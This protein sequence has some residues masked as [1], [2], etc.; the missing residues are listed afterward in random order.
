MSQISGRSRSSVAR[1]MRVNKHFGKRSSENRRPRENARPGFVRPASRGRVT[2]GIR[3]VFGRARVRLRPGE[4]EGAMERSGPSRPGCF[5]G[6]KGVVMEFWCRGEGGIHDT[7]RAGADAVAR[8]A[9]SHD[10]STGS[11]LASDWDWDAT[12]ARIASRQSGDASCKSSS[13]RRVV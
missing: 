11:S 8:I 2:S 4:D 1:S 7:C 6:R 13:H 9:L 3:A 10:T 5:E 12:A